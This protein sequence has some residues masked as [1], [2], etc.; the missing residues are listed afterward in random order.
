MHYYLRKSRFFFED[1]ANVRV[2]GFITNKEGKKLIKLQGNWDDHLNALW[3]EDTEDYPKNHKLQVWKRFDEDFSTQAYKFTKYAMTFNYLSDNMKKTVLSSDSRRRLDRFYL[4]NG[5][6]EK[7]TQWKRVVE[8]QQREDEKTRKANNAEAEKNITSP[9][10]E[11]DKKKEKNPYAKNYWDPVWFDLTVDHVGQPF[12]AY[13]N[14]F[15]ALPDNG[16]MFVHDQVRGTACDF[17]AYELTFGHLLDTT[18]KSSGK[19]VIEKRT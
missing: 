11:D 14:K 10:T 2:K 3:L 15:V 19:I 1:K 4:Q 18:G 8:F 5:D 12:F 6:V 17:E 7:A 16:E 9:R 13:N